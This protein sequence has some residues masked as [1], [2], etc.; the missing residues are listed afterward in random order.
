MTYNTYSD[1]GP[2]A[3]TGVSAGDIQVIPHNPR[4]PDRDPVWPLKY[5]ELIRPTNDQMSQVTVSDESWLLSD[6]NTSS[7]NS[8]YLHHQPTF[9]STITVSDGVLDDALTDYENGVVYFSVLPTGDFTVGY[10]ANPDKYY[11]EYLETIHDLLMKI[12]QILGAGTDAGIA[13]AQLFVNELPAELAAKLPNAIVFSAI[14]RDITLAS[15]TDP[16]AP[17]GTKH[18][19]TLGNYED[20][21]DF[22][23]PVLRV[24]GIVEAGNSGETTSPSV[25]DLQVTDFIQ[26]GDV[27]VNQTLK[28][29]VYGD[30]VVHGDLY[31]QGTHY[32][33]NGSTT[34]NKSTTHGDTFLGDSTDDTAY[35]AGDLDVTGGI[36]AYGVTK[37]HRFDRSIV[38]TDGSLRGVTGHVSTV[39]TLDPSLIEHVRKYYAGDYKR[40][41]VNEAPRYYEIFGLSVDTVV[42]ANQLKDSTISSIWTGNV[43]DSTGWYYYKKYA[44]DNGWYVGIHSG[45]DAGER[46]PIA[47]FDTTTKIWTLTRNLPSGAAASGTTFRIY[48]EGRQQLDFGRSGNN[49][50]LYATTAYPTVCNRD[51]VI[52]IL[53]QNAQVAMPAVAGWYYIFMNMATAAGSA[54]ESQPTLFYSAN[55][56]PSDRAVLLGQAYTNGASVTVGRRIVPN[57][58][59][60]SGWMRFISGSA[61]YNRTWSSN[62]TWAGMY[63]THQYDGNPAGRVSL[64]LAADDGTNKGPTYGQIYQAYPEDQGVRIRVGSGGIYVDMS[65]APSTYHGLSLPFWMR[66]VMR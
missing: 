31:T 62:W 39:D 59:F 26:T 23:V 12:T 64:L 55:P 13:N 5:P 3:D 8:L 34:L 44:Y 57:Q 52:K 17:G 6:I 41:T 50:I 60:D 2:T 18:I 58:H 20:E 45:P 22:H 33:V 48:H 54:E 28:L 42:A 29:A 66:V 51:G 35:V 49:V 7:N 43:N 37:D 21:F 56:N 40:N 47:G 9:Q 32:T 36:T 15:S 46:I 1:L 14:D 10:I 30:A 61:A 38:F 11:G 24:S 27:Y 63:H 19:F 65:A 25:T 16:G 53:T 4:H